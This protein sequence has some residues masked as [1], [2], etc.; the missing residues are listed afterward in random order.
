MPDDHEDRL[1][2]HEAIMEGLARMLAAQHEMNQRVEGFMQRQDTVNDR[3]TAAIERL[4]VTQ[5]RI[6]T[7][8]TGENGR[9]A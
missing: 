9:E 1:R 6:E 2:R 7:L 5:A 8:P 4:D 3:L